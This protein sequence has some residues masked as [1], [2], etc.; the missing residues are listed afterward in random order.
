MSKI[1]TPKLTLPKL[2]QKNIFLISGIT[3]FLL[4]SVLFGFYNNSNSTKISNQ[5]T[6]SEIPLLRGGNEV[7]GVFITSNSQFNSN[8]S[9]ISAFSN[10]FTN[11]I[12]NNSSNNSQ[13]SSASDSKPPNRATISAPVDSLSNAQT[14][15]IQKDL[16]TDFSQKI[17]KIDISQKP[18]LLTETQILGQNKENLLQTGVVK[19]R[20][21]QNL[22]T[23]LDTK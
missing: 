2:L 14:L 15:Q 4:I 11:S 1:T 9:Q 20:N 8:S 3:V 7:D 19:N 6:Q 5:I 22:K 21:F 18:F 16:L 10:N 13:N 12:S 17:T 23:Y